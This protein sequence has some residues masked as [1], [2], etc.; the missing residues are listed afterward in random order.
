MTQALDIV[1]PTLSE[2]GAAVTKPTLAAPRLENITVLTCGLAAGNEEAFR[3]FHRRYFDRLFRLA[4]VLTRGD[5]ATAGDVLQDTL[6]R[7][8]QHARRFDDEE[9]FWCWLV[10]VTRSAA[11][12]AGRKQRR[13]VALLEDYARRWLPLQPQPGNEDDKRLDELT[14]QC[15]DELNAADRALV[16]GKYL[17]RQ[18]VRDLAER[19]D[20]TEKAVESRLG[21]LRQYLR[22]RL[23]DR[24]REDSR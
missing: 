24:L 12:D 7:V 10:A 18:S 8:V 14:T 6:C 1:S 2:A 16:E 21:R 23:L 22:A 11:R 4:L 17:A 19:A 20:L 3:E 9:A 5:Q 15:L 13:Y